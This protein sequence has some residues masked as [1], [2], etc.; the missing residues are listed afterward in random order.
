MARRITEVQQQTG[1]SGG[2]WEDPYDQ[3][4][5]ATYAHENSGSNGFYSFTHRLDKHSF[6]H[7]SNDHYGM[8]RPYS[9]YAPEFFEQEAGSS[10]FQST[11]HVQSNNDYPSM[12]CNVGYLGHQYMKRAGTNSGS[13]GW[14]MH[15]RGMNY[16]PHAFTAC[17]PIVNET[18]QDW[19]WFS[20]DWNSS[21]TRT[22][23]TPRSADIY[24]HMTHWNGN[25]RGSWMDIPCKWSNS[26]VGSSCYNRKLQKMVVMEQNG[27]NYTFRP[28]VWHGCPN[29]RAIATNECMDYDNPEQYNARSRDNN[30]LKTW[31]NSANNAGEVSFSS[32]LGY[33]TYDQWSGKPYNNSTE[34]QYR[35]APVLCDNGK[36]VTFQMLPHSGAW[37]HRWDENGNAEGS[38][39]HY[40]GTTSYGRD[41]GARFGMRW[42]VTSDGR[43]LCAYCPYYYYGSGWIGAFIRVSD[44]KWLWDQNTDQSYGFQICPIGKSSFFLNHTYNSDGGYGMYH[45][46]ANMDQ[47][48]SERSDGDRLSPHLFGGEQHSTIDTAYWSTTYPVLIP[49]MYNTHAFTTMVE[50]GHSTVEGAAKQ[51]EFTTYT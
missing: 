32:S 44:G 25:S 6:T 46:M 43:Y 19:A 7:G 18:K 15:T 8:Y 4:C 2:T 11:S 47:Q 34:D 14:I 42:Q 38:R 36:V 17:N 26:A 16:I 22:Y 23:F 12:T 51:T 48:F 30:S 33:T 20:D 29:F 21:R 9:S 41:Q 10:Y 50:G 13:G 1:G 5:F 40:S 27:G 24:R 31:M 49:A 45:T 39:R 37:V 35:C 28:I 3:P